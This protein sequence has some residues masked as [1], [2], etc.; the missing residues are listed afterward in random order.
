MN[1]RFGSR[2]WIASIS[3]CVAFYERVSGISGI[4]KRVMRNREPEEQRTNRFSK[5]R[6]Q[7]RV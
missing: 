2:R 1:V 5:D 6:T 7:V 3:L 4:I